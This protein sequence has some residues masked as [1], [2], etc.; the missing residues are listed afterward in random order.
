VEGN[1]YQVGFDA[2]WEIDLFGGKRRAVEAANAEIGA[3]IENRRQV[4]VSL[5]AEVARNYVELRA[6]QR[7]IGIARDNL[8]AQQ[9]TLDLTRVRYQAGL[10]SDLDV[11][12]A[13]AQVQNTSSQIPLLETSARQSMH[14][15]SVLLG[16]EPNALVSELSSEAPIPAAPT[17]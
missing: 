9:E 12:R 17:E 7:R 16:Q 2:S 4:L 13:E 11:A 14:L 5:L 1:L 15:L 6:S 8:N 10:V 3:E